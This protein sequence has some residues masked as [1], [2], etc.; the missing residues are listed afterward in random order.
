M[1]IA[2]DF[3]G[4]I[5]RGEYP[6]IEGLQPYARESVNQLQEQ[7]HYIIIWTCRTN[8][9]L[10]TAINWLLAQGIKFNRVNAGNPDNVAK[11]GDEGP[12]VYADVYIDDRNL[13]GFPG[14]PI[15][16]ETIKNMETT[17]NTQPPCN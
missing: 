2:I 12:K 13:G 15:A 8:G 3:D 9:H 7:G 5:C 17:P 4:T 11:Y 16:L 14:W 1:I 10:L 6:A